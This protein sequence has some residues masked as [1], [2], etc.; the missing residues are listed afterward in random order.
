[1]ESR[2]EEVVRLQCSGETGR[3]AGRRQS[4]AVRAWSCLAAALVGLA[5]TET[6]GPTVES[7]VEL[8]ACPLHRDIAPSLRPVYCFDD[9][10]PGRDAECG[11]DCSS[12]SSSDNRAGSSADDATGRCPN[13][14]VRGGVCVVPIPTDYEPPPGYVAVSA[15][16]S[17]RSGAADREARQ[18]PFGRG[19]EARVFHPF[20]LKATEVTQREWRERMGN[21]PSYFDDCGG[22]CAVDSLSW[23]AAIAYTNELSSSQN[24]EP[25]YVTDGC[26]G[27]YG[28]DFECESVE[29]RGLDCEGYRLPLEAEWEHAADPEQSRSIDSYPAPRSDHRVGRREP[30]AEGLYDMVGNVWEWTEIWNAGGYPTGEAWSESRPAGG[31]R[32]VIRGC[33]RGG[34]ARCCP[35]ECRFEYVLGAR[36]DD[37][38]FR[39]AR[40]LYP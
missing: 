7:G 18:L 12:S 24:L 23:Y 9:P 5:A 38:G 36:D 16:G 35:L 31:V 26:S 4:K 13:G 10:D 21:N 29:F 1:M 6:A 28:E 33:E 15:D 34:E 30:N 17:G 37:V 19:R 8:L 11:P 22:D 3:R 32:V 20:L 40:T 27:V 2:Y 25:C 39:P 14:E